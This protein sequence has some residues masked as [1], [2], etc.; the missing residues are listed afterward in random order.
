MNRIYKSVWNEQTATFVA[1]AEN[2]KAR[3]KRSSGGACVSQA[4]LEW[5]QGL[6]LRTV[7]L[8]LL[9][10]GVLTQ[11]AMAQIT[12]G[13]ELA[14][15]GAIP[16]HVIPGG[17]FSLTSGNNIALTQTGGTVAVALNPDL[18]VDSVTASGLVKG[19]TGEF[20]GQLTAGSATVQGNLQA[21]TATIPNQLTAPSAVIDGNLAAKSAT[22][23]GAVHV[24]GVNTVSLTATGNTSLRAV[25]VNNNKI[26]GLADA[27]VNASSTEAVS[28]KVL[29]GVLNSGDGIK[30]FH[31]SSTKADSVASGTDSIAIGPQATSSGEAALAAGLESEATGKEAIALG[32]RSGTGNTVENGIAIGSDAG[33][34][35]KGSDLTRVASLRTE[36][37]QHLV[38][39]Q[40]NSLGAR[41]LAEASSGNV[42]ALLVLVMEN[43]VAQVARIGE[44][45]KQ[46]MIY[47]S[48]PD[49]AAAQRLLRQVQG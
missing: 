7:A 35:S 47:L 36:Q 25:N 41:K 49:D 27:V 22:V 3:G 20:T 30:Y 46:G 39:F 6:R 4:V 24:G 29:Y 21:N 13:W 17:A 45:L 32:A 33:T 31:G 9:S 18:N 8:A 26:S 34:T 5:V 15:D 1:V 44:P 40:L 10:A 23:L 16:F 19:A 11:P 38:R 48:M 42:G 43:Q 37:G 28:G 12:D 14:V 2:T